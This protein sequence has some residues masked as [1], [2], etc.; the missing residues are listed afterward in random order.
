M[1][2]STSSPPSRG[3]RWLLALAA[4]PLCAAADSVQLAEQPT[5]RATGPDVTVFAL[6]DTT[7]YGIANGVR[8]YS[9]GTTSCN[10]G[11]A[12]L[13][14][15]DNVGGCGMGT[16]G[17]DHPVIAQNIYRLKDGR[18]TQIGASWLKH[19]FLSVN[20]SNSACGTCQIPPLGGDQ[21]GVG[22]T[23]PYGSGLNGSRPMGRKSEVDPTTGA[24]PFPIGGGGSTAAVWNQRVAVN[25]SDLIAAQNVGARYF[26]EGHY[27]APDDARADNGLNNASYREVSVN[28]GNFNLSFV[29][30][31]VREKAAIQAWA[32]ID[33]TVELVNVDVPD[34]RPVQRFHV[35]RKVTE[36]TPGLWRY[37][38]AVHNMNASRSA[39]RLTV[40]F[41]TGTTI[42][43]VGFHGVAAHSGEP[44]DTAAW[45]GVISA[46]MVQWAAPAFPSAPQNA[47]ALRWGTMYSFWFEADRGPQDI[48][49]HELGLFTGTPTEVVFLA[50][51][52]TLFEDGF[53]DP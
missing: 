46:D 8:G 49:Q 43:G 36:T 3:W 10:V 53:E 14:W 11:T 17:N 27:V 31:T 34:S 37:E 51:S 13:N 52:P 24:F 25:E 50:N 15:C 38:Y 20:S 44:Y 29:G 21:L 35:A 32:D 47:N 30:A 7:N 26:A 2:N 4:L 5:S 42:T 39:D 12:P 16:T 28:Q 19:G 41:A 22:C 9:I 45:P 40:R 48:L 18:L 33:S 23:D 1:F 6:S